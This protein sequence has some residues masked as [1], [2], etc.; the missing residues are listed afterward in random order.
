MANYDHIFKCLPIY[1]AAIAGDWETAERFFKDEKKNFNAPITYE[2]D[3]ALHVAVGTNSSHRFVKE[4]VELIMDVD[5]EMLL[6]ANCYGNNVLHYAA[7]V[8]NT[9]AARLL[10]NK[11]PELAQIAKPNGHT[12]L[13]LAARYGH[14]ETLCYLLEVTKDVVGEEGTSPYRGHDGADLLTLSI[15]ADYYDVALYLV[16][17]YPHLVTE[18]NNTKS[19]TGLEILAAKPNA[20]RSGRR[21]RFWQRIIYPWIPVNREKALESPIIRVSQITTH[22]RSKGCGLHVSFWSLLQYLAPH[23]KHMHD[24]KVMHILT[25]ELVKNMCSTVIKKGDHAIAWDVLGTTLRTAV[26]HGI[27]ELIEECIHQYPGLLWYKMGEFFLVLVAIRQRQE[28]VYNLVYQ[29]SGHKVYTAIAWKEYANDDTALHL[30]AR[31]AP[32]HRLNTVTGAALQMQRELQWF[33]EVEKFVQPSYKEALNNENKTPRMVFTREHKELLNEA[34]QWMKDTSSSATVVA[35]LIVTM[36]FAAIFTAPGGNNNDGKSLFLNDPIFMLFAISDAVALFSSS[37]SVLMF[38]SVLS[39][40][41]AEDDFLYALPKRLTL[42]LISLFVSLAA[43]MVAFS[44]TLSL[45][46]HDKIQWIAAPVILLA[47]VPVTLFLLLQYPLLVELVSSTYGRGIF[48]KQ[49]NLLLH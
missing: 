5:P 20:F 7:M 12:P 24:S 46:L 23:I 25:E 40:R 38:L 36:A 43:T 34:Q 8:G 18:R 3:T 11:Y 31:L 45:V 15:I 30:A 49:N 42:G 26:T 48:Y 27:Y 37:T 32:Q 44:A 13:K 6:T 22:N 4:L 33:K 17:E 29:M 41:F 19:Q 35:A 16:K 9:Q 1:K 39:S 21:I 14:K 10:V 2:S 47:S 28:K